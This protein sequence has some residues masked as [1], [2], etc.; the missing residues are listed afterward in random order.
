MLSER[1]KVEEKEYGRE[2]RKNNYRADW[3]QI[4]ESKREQKKLMQKE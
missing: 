3:R 2:E 4:N 1:N